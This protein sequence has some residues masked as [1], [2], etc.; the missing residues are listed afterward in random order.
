MLEDVDELDEVDTDD[1]FETR[2]LADVDTT[3]LIGLDDEEERCGSGGSAL[4]EELVF[5]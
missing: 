3:K 1:E 2:E 4:L 5:D